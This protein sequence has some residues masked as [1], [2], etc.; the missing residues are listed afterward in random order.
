MNSIN[1][2][3]VGEPMADLAVITPSYAPDL[4]LCSDL[5]ESVLRNTPESVKH[6]I[7]TPRRDVKLFSRLRSTRTEVLSVD[8]VL[9]RHVLSVPG[10]N[11]WLNL[12]HPLPPVRGWVMQQI[13][14]LQMAS[15]I[16]A[17]LVLSADSD[18]LLVRPV[19]SATFRQGGRVRFY[20]QDKMI[21]SGM[22]FHLIWHD[23]ARKLLGVPTAPPLPLSDY[24]M[25]LNL[26][27]RS[28]VIALHERIQQTTGE[29]WLDVVAKQRHFSEDILYG[30]F[31]DEVL[32]A[33]AN[34][35]AAASMLCHSYWGSVPLDISAANK[36]VR[37]MP[38]NDVA[39]MISA[40]SGTPLDVRRRA[41]SKL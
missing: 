35:V 4:E 32:G 11:Y 27:E 17:D 6:Y 8:E 23:V 15:Q 1:D 9:P 29:H 31:V 14:R 21:H 10:V 41:L 12:R 39:I 19:T 22:P 20:R 40:K 2:G 36:F 3:R 16:T 13:I 25:P 38:I 30:I 18:V 26:W 5:H 34:V 7:I 37:E 24:I 33:R 28:T